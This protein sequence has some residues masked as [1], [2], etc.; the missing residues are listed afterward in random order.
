M[1]IY[2]KDRTETLYDDKKLHDT[3]VVKK[4]NKQSTQDRSKERKNQ[5][6]DMNQ[7]RRGM[8]LRSRKKIAYKEIYNAKGR[9][10]H[11]APRKSQCTWTFRN[12]VEKIQ[13]HIGLNVCSTATIRCTINP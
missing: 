7:S 4:N 5:I 1:G 11:P 6:W 3:S 8:G 10:A 13:Y 12:D 2:V 9:Y